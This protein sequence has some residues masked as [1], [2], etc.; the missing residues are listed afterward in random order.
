MDRGLAPASRRRAATI[1]IVGPAKQHDANIHRR[2]ALQQSGLFLRRAVER[3]FLSGA[4][5]ARPRTG[6]IADRS[7]A[8]QPLHGYRGRF[9]ARGKQGSCIDH[10]TH[11]R[12]GA[13]RPPAGADPIIPRLFL[14]CAFRP[15]RIRRIAPARHSVGEFLLQ[16]HSSI[17]SSGRD[18]GRGRLCLAHRKAGAPFVSRDRRQSGLGADGRRAVVLSSE[19]EPGARRGGLLHRPALRRPRP[20]AGGID[21]R[22]RAGGYLR[23][24][25]GRTIACGRSGAIVRRLSRPPAPAAWKPAE[26]HR[27]GRSDAAAA[28]A[29]L[30]LATIAAPMALRSRDRSAGSLAAAATPAVPRRWTIRPRSSA[31]TKCA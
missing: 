30:G 11:R 3:Q 9:H 14:Q 18:R 4:A 19:R 28:G 15:G 17:R 23:V 10:R 21:P 1:V 8:G 20:L 5:R 29:G 27:R 16:Q 7:A 31:A 6:R 26:L 22:R 13:C 2:P 24:G 12:R 25:L